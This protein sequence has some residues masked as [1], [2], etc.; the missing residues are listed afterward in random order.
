MHSDF[1]GAK[2]Q[3]FE[4]FEYRWMFLNEIERQLDKVIH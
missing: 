3:H 4:N 2:I 1:V